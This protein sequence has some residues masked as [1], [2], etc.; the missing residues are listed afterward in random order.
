MASS[1][2]HET[3]RHH[4]SALCLD[5]VEPVIRRKSRRNCVA[6]RWPTSF[7]ICPIPRSV[8]RNNRT[9]CS[10]RT[11]CT[12][13][14]GD[15]PQ[16]ATT[17][18][19]SVRLLTPTPRATS[20]IENC[21]ERCRR[22]QTSARTAS[23]CG[24]PV[25]PTMRGL[26]DVSAVPMACESAAATTWS[27]RRAT[28]VTASSACASR[29]DAQNT[30]PASVTLDVSSTIADG[31]I[32]RSASESAGAVVQCLWSSRPAWPSRR[33]EAPPAATIPPDR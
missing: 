28:R 10:K 2:W 3:D 16:A 15:K 24:V 12:N 11:R 13:P 29:E 8:S 7:A 26:V 6:S 22:T 32:R 20:P 17:L 27:A 14:W 23:G 21:Q 18:R 4:G 5:G 19:D 25:A 9:A 31:Y 1:A 33:V 30:L